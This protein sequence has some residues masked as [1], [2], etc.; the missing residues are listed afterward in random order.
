MPFIPDESDGTDLPAFAPNGI[1]V[2]V[3]CEYSATVRDAFRARGFD[4]WSC[5]LLPT[6]GDPR[7]HIQGDALEVAYGQHWDLM[8]CHPTCTYATNSGVCH[9][10]KDAGRW[11]K[12]FESM[13]FMQALLDAPIRHIALENPIMHKYARQLLGGRKHDQIVQ[14]WMFG[15]PEQ[16]ATGLM[17]KNLPKLKPTNNVREQMMAL[18]DKDRQRLHYLSPGPDRWKE[19]SRTFRGIADAMAKQFG[20]YLLD[21][22]SGDL[23][24]G[25]RFIAGGS[26]LP[27]F[28]NQEVA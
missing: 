6:E 27:F 20:S 15:H 13:A 8:V 24:H 22:T 4:A 5:D 25:S 19:R 21:H 12:L 18:P 10:H 3:A 17:L 1:R 16:K 23:P 28:H 9:L 11:P 7:W 26:D 2:L 14:P